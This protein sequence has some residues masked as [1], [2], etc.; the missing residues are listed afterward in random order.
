MKRK[1]AGSFKSC[2]VLLAVI[3]LTFSILSGC[4]GDSRWAEEAPEPMFSAPIF[5]T[6]TVTEAPAQRKGDGVLTLNFASGYSMN[7]FVTNSETNLFL[8]GLLFET[9]ITVAPGFRAEPGVLAEWSEEAGI[10]FKFTLRSGARFSD[11]S[12]IRNWDVLYSLNRARENGS[13]FQSRLTDIEEA[14]IEGSSIVIRLKEANPSFLLRLDIP[15]VKEGTAYSDLPVG[16]GPYVFSK[17]NTGAELTASIT[18]PNSKDLPLQT[19]ALVDLP[20][21]QL[22]AAFSDGTV[23]MLV[24]GTGTDVAFLVPGDSDRR[25]LDTSIFHFLFV[26]QDSRALADPHRRRLVSAALNRNSISALLGGSVSLSP[27]SMST[28]LVSNSWMEDWLPKDLE[29]FKIDILTEDYDGDGILEYFVDGEPRDLILRLLYCADSSS[30]TLAASRIKTDLQGVGISI[31]LV[32][33]EMSEY[34]SM[35]RSGDYDLCLASVRLT[36]DF[37]LTPLLCSGGSMYYGGC[38]SELQ[39]AVKAFRSAEEGERE[40]CARVLCILLAQECPIL[41]ICFGR[42]VLVIGRGVA[43]G[44]SPTW[45][46]PFRNPMDWIPGSI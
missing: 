1:T 14:F 33:A 10:L 12:D 29:A 15:V 4:S 22:N 23:D 35:L 27:I 36:S 44:L 9:M 11:G 32:P 28:G 13:H 8:S 41:P 20:Q 17:T 31:I 37:D 34:R 5:I 25:Y 16:S 26:S 18:Y 46:D 21:E 30:S 38:S 24:S 42:N 6:P 2:I 19:I 39:Q 40:E 3:A 45:T 7:P 43:Q